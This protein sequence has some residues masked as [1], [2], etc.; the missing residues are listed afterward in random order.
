MEGH[1]LLDLRPGEANA[2]K[3]I[4]LYNT[5]ELDRLVVALSKVWR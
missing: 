1:G 2:M 3:C 5:R 4:D